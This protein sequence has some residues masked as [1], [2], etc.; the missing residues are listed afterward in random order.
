VELGTRADAD[1]MVMML[2]LTAGSQSSSLQAG[3]HGANDFA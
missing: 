2:G 1:A 3:K